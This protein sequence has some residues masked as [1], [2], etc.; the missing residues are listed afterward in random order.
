MAHL[1]YIYW[2]MTCGDI[3]F[4]QNY[5]DFQKVSKWSQMVKNEYPYVRSPIIKYYIVYSYISVH[6][7]ATGIGIE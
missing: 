3:Q 5:Q 6:I 4:S 7:V 2:D 1:L